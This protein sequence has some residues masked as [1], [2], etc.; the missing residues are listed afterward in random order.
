M[1]K[2]NAERLCWDPKAIFPMFLAY[3]QGSVQL[4]RQRWHVN[5]LHLTCTKM[6]NQTSTREGD[7]KLPK[8][9]YSKPS[10]WQVMVPAGKKKKKE[11]KGNSVPK[12]LLA[13]YQNTCHI[14]KEACKSWQSHIVLTH[15]YS[16]LKWR[17]VQVCT[18]TPQLHTSQRQGHW[19]WT[20]SVAR[21]QHT[22]SDFPVHELCNLEYQIWRT[23]VSADFKSC[24]DGL[25]FGCELRPPEHQAA[26]WNK[27]TSDPQVLS[28]YR[29]FRCTYMEKELHHGTYVRFGMP[30]P[31]RAAGAPAGDRR[32]D[33]GDCKPSFHRNPSIC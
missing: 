5:M 6:T 28:L 15:Q 22:T 27:Q 24:T 2:H 21:R 31:C 25:K 18:L 12:N 13:N 16:P 10:F 3:R 9:S 32:L 7:Q 23:T 33:F 14:A 29:L 20:A 30:V 17:W 4:C 19:V 8:S 11:L 26:N 1:R